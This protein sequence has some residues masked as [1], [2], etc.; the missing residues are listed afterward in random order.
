MHGV[1]QILIGVTT[2]QKPAIALYESRG[3]EAFGVEPHMIR[4]GDEYYD[5]I[6][7]I[8]FL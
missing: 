8:K 6:H 5:I 1:E 4:V 2:T 3:F 7:M